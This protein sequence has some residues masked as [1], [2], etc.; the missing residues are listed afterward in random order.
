MSR[1]TTGD[2]GLLVAASSDES[3]GLNILVSR[4]GE[5]LEVVVNFTEK[6]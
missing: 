1:T 4:S 6:N 3:R 2:G 5:G